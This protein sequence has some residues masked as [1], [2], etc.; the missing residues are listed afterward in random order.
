MM[1]SAILQ[2]YIG[3]DVTHKLVAGIIRHVAHYAKGGCPLDYVLQ[4]YPNEGQLAGCAI[5]S[6]DLVQE[7]LKGLALVASMEK[8]NE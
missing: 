6:A 8:D 4:L 1:N 3:P 7:H 5:I 2:P